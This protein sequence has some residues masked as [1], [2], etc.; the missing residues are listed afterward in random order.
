MIRNACLA[1]LVVAALC[2]PARAEVPVSPLGDIYK[3][4]NDCFDVATKDGIKPE[5]LRSLGWSK[6]TTSKNGKPTT[7]QLP[8]FGHPAR[9]PLITLSAESGEGLCIVLARLENAG[10]FDEFKKPFGNNLPAPAADGTISFKALGHVVQLRRTGTP[11]EPSMSIA[12]MT[13]MGSK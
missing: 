1:A 2:A 6:A 4:Y 13:P 9:K 8:I 12:V 3:S 10:S 11:A 7:D 5:V